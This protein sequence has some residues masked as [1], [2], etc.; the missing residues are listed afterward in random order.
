MAC[1]Y[2]FL[3]RKSFHFPSHSEFV[4]NQ[5]LLSCE[6]TLPLSTSHFLTNKGNLLDQSRMLTTVTSHD[7]SSED[8][9]D[10]HDLTDCE[11]PEL[12]FDTQSKGSDSFR[13]KQEE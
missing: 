11:E 5:F 1:C 4:S 2:N 9:E 12:C 13:Y 3:S 7:I 10:Y 6:A 8:S